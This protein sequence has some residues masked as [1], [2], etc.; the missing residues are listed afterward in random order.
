MFGLGNLI[1]AVGTL[2]SPVVANVSK[3]LFIV[4][5]VI[6]GLAEVTHTNRG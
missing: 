2:L 6:E 1:T 5:R 3:E 4:V